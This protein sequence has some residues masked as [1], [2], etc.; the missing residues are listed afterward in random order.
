MS[1]HVPVPHNERL[2]LT[3]LAALDILDTQPS[4]GFDRV[5]NLAREF[6]R[7]PM[8][9]VSFVDAD[10]QWF[11]A[12]SGTDLDGSPRAAAFCA[13]TILSPELL[14]VPDARSDPRFSGSS[15]V[16]GAPLIRFYAGAPIMLAPGVALGAVCI[17]D[18]IA[19]TLD[20]AGRVVLQQ[21]AAIAVSELRLILAARAC[22]RRDYG[23]DPSRPL[24]RT[25][26]PPPASPAL[27]RP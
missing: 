3:H 4:A 18:R 11:K 14:V 17:A 1:A 27:S 15:L 9:M 5:C 2:R 7:T 16:T 26:K 23:I 10:R 24:A 20:G 21:L 25:Q 12:R 8:A 6:F 22:F 19:R 13:H